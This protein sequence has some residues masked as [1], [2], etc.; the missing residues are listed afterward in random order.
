MQ[1]VSIDIKD[2]RVRKRLESLKIDKS[3]GP[4]GLSPRVLIELSAV[5]CQPLAILLKYSIASS[6]IS[7]KWRFAHIT[8]LFKKGDKKVVGNISLLV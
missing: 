2:E 5:L 7:N 3:P 1:I 6:E 4:D 8:D